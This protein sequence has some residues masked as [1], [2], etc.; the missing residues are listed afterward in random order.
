VAKSYKIAVIGGDGTGPEVTREAVKVLRAVAALEGFTVRLTEFDFGGERYLKTGRIISDEEVEELKK[1][2]AIL[3]G[4]VGHPDVAP[5]ILEK[6]LLLKLRFQLDQYINLRPVKLYPGVETP[7]AGRKPEDIDFA[8]IRENTEGLYTGMGGVAY[9]GTPHEVATQIMCNTRMGVERC[10]RFA[11]DY[12]RK[13]GDKKM[14]TLVA[15]TNVLTYCSD[16][17]WRTFNEV[18]E[19][20]YPDIKRDYNHVDACCM[21]MVK[22]PEYYDTIVVGNMFGDIITDLAAMIQGGLG[23]AAGGNINPKTVSMFEPIGGSAPKYT[24]KNVINPIAAIGAV[25]MMLDFLGE[26]K[27]AARVEKAIMAVTGTKMKSQS[28]GKMGYGTTEVGDLVC[29][30][31]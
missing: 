15:K 28:A 27:A 25:R 23:V 30:A 21:W 26:A 10:V 2:D 13:R 17:W 5:G 3:L 24:G 18:G 20:D 8:I 11:F 9:K 31:L 19:K 1:F 22:N 4:A 14:L 6:G 29:Q 12:C 16:L 7:L